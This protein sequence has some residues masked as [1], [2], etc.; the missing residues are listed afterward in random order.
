MYDHRSDG[1]TDRPGLIAEEVAEV[2]S[3][4]VRYA[5]DMKFDSDGQ[6]MRNAD[7]TPIL[8]SDNLVAVNYDEQAMIAQLVVAIQQLNTRTKTIEDEVFDTTPPTIT[9]SDKPDAVSTDKNP[10]FTFSAN[11]AATFEVFLT[12]WKSWQAAASPKTFS[13]LTSGTRTFSVRATDLKGNVSAPTT[14]TWEIDLTNNTLATFGYPDWTG[15]IQNPTTNSS[16]S[17]PDHTTQGNMA[18]PSW[19]GTIQNPA[20]S[21]NFGTVAHS[22]N[23]LFGEKHWSGTISNPATTSNFSKPSHSIGANFNANGKLGW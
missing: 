13:N 17:S 14:Y 23:N 10:A 11:E 9:L 19:T 6:L 4:L 2:H 21:S 5:P 1:Y 22:L 18:Y 15:A 20:I 16:F 3:S 8:E 12:G 7:R